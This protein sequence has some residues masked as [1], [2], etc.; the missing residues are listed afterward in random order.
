VVFIEDVLAVPEHLEFCVSLMEA[1]VLDRW[2]RDVDLGLVKYVIGV[3]RLLSMDKDWAAPD[4]KRECAFGTR[5]Y[6]TMMRGR[7]LDPSLF[8]R[9]AQALGVG[10]SEVIDSA[11]DMRERF[12]PAAYDPS[13][14]AWVGGRISAELD[15]RGIS[16]TRL[17]TALA[18]SKASITALVR[19]DK[20][21]SALFVAAIQFLGADPE[22][23]LDS[24]YQ[25]VHQAGDG[26][27]REGELALRDRE[28]RPRGEL[29]ISE[30]LCVEGVLFAWD[31]GGSCTKCVRE[32][33]GLSTSRVRALDLPFSSSEMSGHVELE[34]TK[35]GRPLSLS[36][37]WEG[38]VSFVASL[39]QDT[40][41]VVSRW[42]ISSSADRL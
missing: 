14:Y 37:V 41:E 13:G 15:D 28:P 42:Q 33:G 10:L 32:A 8:G 1:D 5:D 34:R 21:D 22:A 12:G 6:N 40:L 4:I 20:G 27:R 31:S 3:L 30:F 11:Q 39:S 26:D 19:G 35:Q 29:G 16:R 38:G 17:A 2:S 23:F 25:G 9:W 24:A 7:C 36:V 18:S